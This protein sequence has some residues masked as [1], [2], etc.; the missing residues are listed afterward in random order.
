[1]KYLSYIVIAL[2]VSAGV[3]FG[4][5]NRAKVKPVNDKQASQAVGQNQTGWETKIDDQ[6]SITIKVTP[7]ILDKTSDPWKFDIT[8]D[9]HSGSLDQDPLEMAVLFD[10]KGVAHKPT[11]WE[12]QRPGGHHREGMLIFKA[13]KPAPTYVA[14]KIKNVGGIPE[15]SFTWNIKQPL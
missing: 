2:I 8:F 10:D 9:T 3:Y 1:M 7:V 13:I 6:S 5:F 12:G 11:A 4:F 14:L 15:R